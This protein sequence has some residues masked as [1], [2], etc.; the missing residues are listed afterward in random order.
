MP[1]PAL[2]VLKG[3]RA[4]F[5]SYMFSLHAIVHISTWLWVFSPCCLTWVRPFGA[6]H[7]LFCWEQKEREKFRAGA[8]PDTSGNGTEG[9]GRFPPTLA[10]RPVRLPVHGLCD[11]ERLTGYPEEHWGVQ[12]K[13]MYELY[14]GRRMKETKPSCDLTSQRKTVLTVS[15]V[16]QDSR[17][18]STDPCRSQ[19]AWP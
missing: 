8:V 7:V 12:R 16:R 3:T 5:F 9:R 15:S 2:C 18:V 4:P 14:E 10:L 19:I 17:M 13:C 11:C 6:Y 1:T